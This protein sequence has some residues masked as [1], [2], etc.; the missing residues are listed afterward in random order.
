MKYCKTT[1]KKESLPTNSEVSKMKIR[2]LLAQSNEVVSNKDLRKIYDNIDEWVQDNDVDYRDLVA[3]L[4]QMN[5]GDMSEQEDINSSTKYY[6]KNNKKMVRLFINV[7]R[8]QNIKPKDILGAIAGESGIPG[9]SV[10]SIDMFDKYTFVD[11]PGKYAKNVLRS[12]K[13]TK[14]KG[15]TI[16]IETANKK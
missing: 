15:R 11:V 8:K 7:G 4:I 10:G 3:A 1:I 16:N 9:K 12:M 13:R 6:E 14:I 2:K 5:I